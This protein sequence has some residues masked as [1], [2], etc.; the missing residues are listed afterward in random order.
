M[1]KTIRKPLMPRLPVSALVMMKARS[2]KQEPRRCRSTE[3]RKAL[4]D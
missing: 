3:R 1:S 4:E 2:K